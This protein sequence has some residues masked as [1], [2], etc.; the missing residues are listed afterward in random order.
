M[1]PARPG[2]WG[3]LSPAGATREC[4][5]VGGPALTRTDP[6]R[7]SAQDTDTDGQPW[8]GRGVVVPQA[9][10]SPLTRTAIFLVVTIDPGS[11]AIARDL[12]SALSGLQRAVGFRE[13]QGRLSCVTGIGSQAWTVCSAGRGPPS[14]IPSRS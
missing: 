11:E 14:C 8:T 2:S 9:V 5:Q 4:C 1:N 3:R 12:L 7:T 10:L 6:G 13:P